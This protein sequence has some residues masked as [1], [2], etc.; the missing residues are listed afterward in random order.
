VTTGTRVKDLAIDS[1]GRADADAACPNAV[2]LR[3]P[4]RLSFGAPAAG[5][6]VR[7][8]ALAFA[9]IAHV[10]GLYLLAHPSE[11]TSLGAG[12]HEI[13]AISVTLVSSKV[14]E[15]RNPTLTQ[16]DAAAASGAV[17]ALDGATDKEPAIAAAQQKE[18]VKEETREA[19][20]HEEEPIPNAEAI[21][22]VPKDAQPK[23]KQQAAAPAAGGAEAQ[24]N[25]ASDAT[26]SAPAAAS[27]GVV[28]EYAHNVA[29]TLRKARP[30]GAG[31]LGTVRVKFSIELDG[32]VTSVEV[33]KSSGNGKLDELAVAAVRR[34]KF[35]TPPQGLTSAER[36]YELPYY[37][38]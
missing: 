28:R 33:A 14:L 29:E 13:D 27:A 5:R 22:Q 20:K 31:A 19:R 2:P 8:A 10:G 25:R 23:P 15:A 24:S 7:A 36:F 34:T 12:G 18:T 3:V 16:A 4:I 32:S 17:Q 1:D 35:R 11:E 9:L 21:F 30:K 6:P 37:F 26:A 38:R